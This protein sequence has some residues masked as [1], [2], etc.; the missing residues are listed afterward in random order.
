MAPVLEPSHWATSTLGVVLLLC[1]AVGPHLPEWI[2][3]PL[4]A[5]GRSRDLL[6]A[7]VGVRPGQE[8]D[9]AR[10]TSVF[11]GAAGILCVI[12]LALSG[13]YLRL[14]AYFLEHFFWTPLTLVL[15]NAIGLGLLLGA[16]W[17]VQGLIVVMLASGRGWG[18]PSPEPHWSP[19]GQA[20]VGCA[21]AWATA[22][23][24][25]DR[26][27]SGHQLYLIGA[28]PLFVMSV[29]CVGVRRAPLAAATQ[30]ADLSEAPDL[31]GAD[32]WVCVG[33][34]LTWAMGAVFV[35]GGLAG[36]G[37]AG[38]SGWYRS[39]SWLLLG[40]GVGGL[41]RWRGAL[42]PAAPLSDA[43]L[44]MWVCGLACAGALRIQPWGSWNWFG[45]LVA[46]WML[47]YVLHWLE[48]ASLARLGRERLVCAQLTTTVSAGAAAGLAVAHWWALPLLGSAGL[49]ILGVLTL[50]GTA[51]ILQIY[52]QDRPSHVRH[53]R[54]ALVFATLGGAILIFPGEVRQALQRERT[55]AQ[56]APAA[57]M[58][59]W[60]A[61]SLARARSVCWLGP[62]RPEELRRR[63]DGRVV[64]L[65]TTGG[66][67]GL[68][69]PAAM[70]VLTSRRRFDL[71]Y[72]CWPQ[73]G[74]RFP[75]YSLEWFTRLVDA[76]GSDGRLVVDVPRAGLSA[77]ALDVIAFTFLQACGGRAA[78][79]H[80]SGPGGDWLR[81]TSPAD[82]PHST[83]GHSLPQ[84]T[85]LDADAGQA[86][87][88][89]SLT[90]DQLTLRL[91]A[92]G[93]SPRTANLTDR[94]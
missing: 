77:A 89:H 14:H 87:A 21:L 81:L 43:G 13:P 9:R 16:A 24:W 15:L 33:S 50:L 86:R 60:L 62:A 28:L 39:C 90:R 34:L 10:A 31:A 73:A 70:N 88:V 12:Q 26:G 8:T 57:A 7:L 47:G 42:R 71:L 51:G 74:E 67:E 54:L 59:A 69:S 83:S 53:A 37:P 52:T 48:Q 93:S 4:R 66:G 46:G 22:S 41:G 11:C 18:R 23:A 91:D 72:Q 84:W 75:Q 85:T 79:A 35:M 45:L 92:G 82:L 58:D 27:M 40:I 78:A 17:C 65:P 6:A 49:L 30:P 1:L 20:I 25:L 32:V 44:W 61:E 80:L 94:H 76:V 5:L 29:V 64:F 36:S 19:A 63:A 2:A 55:A 3:G 68:R 56:E 38:S